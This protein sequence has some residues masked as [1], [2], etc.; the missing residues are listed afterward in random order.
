MTK[1][2][3]TKNK[4][5]TFNYELLDRYEAGIVLSGMEVKSIKNSQINISDAFIRFDKDEAWLWN[6][7]IPQYKYSSDA[8]YE[9]KRSRKLLLHKSQINSLQSNLNTK[10]YA[11]VPTLVY[12]VGGKVKVEIALGKGRKSHEKQRRVKE[13]ELDRDLH[14]DKRQYMVE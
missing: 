14:R 8:S 10:G 5:A 4:K 11:V 3:I 12:L 13:R 6:A 2:I 7:D 9:P 1:K